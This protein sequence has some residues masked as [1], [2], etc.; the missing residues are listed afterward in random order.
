MAKITLQNASFHGFSFSCGPK[1]GDGAAIVVAE[2]SAPWTVGNR[3]AG[4]WEE[5]PETVSGN[6]RLVPN[7]FAANH[8]EFTPRGGKGFSI[9]CSLA[10]SFQCFVP[11]K[12]GTP[13]ELRFKISTSALEAGL[14]LEAFGRVSG[15]MPGTFKLSQ[16]VADTQLDLT[17]S[18]KQPT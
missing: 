13:R 6:I 5:V 15:A 9:D 7:E 8:I 16:D 2:F 18:G 4:K 17:K 11:T 1:R 3:S 10:H 14:E 12:E